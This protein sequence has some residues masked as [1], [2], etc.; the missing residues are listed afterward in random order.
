[1]SRGW[2]NALECCPPVGTVGLGVAGCN[3]PTNTTATNH[4]GG[5]TKRRPYILRSHRAHR[6]SPYDNRGQRIAVSP[7]R[8]CGERMASPLAQTR[9]ARTHGE[10]AD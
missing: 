2:E 10:Q 3:G 8:N 6:S 1:M 9:F 4:G 7:N 5:E